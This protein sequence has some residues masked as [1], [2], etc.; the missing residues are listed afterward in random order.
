MFSASALPVMSSD[1][2]PLTQS[3]ECCG[4]LDHMLAECTVFREMPVADRRSLVQRVRA[5]YSCLRSRSMHKDLKYCYRKCLTDGCHSEHHALL[6]TMREGNE[7][8]PEGQCNVNMVC[9]NESFLPTALVPVVYGSAR[10]TA[11]I[12]FD[13]FSQLTFVTK[14]V[15]QQL[16]LPMTKPERITIKG[17]GA[18]TTERIYCKTELSLVPKNE[19]PPVK[20]EA[21]VCEGQICETLAAV[22]IDVSQYTHLMHVPLADSFPR[23]PVELDVLV[24]SALFWR[25][26]EGPVSQPVEAMV[27]FA[28]KTVFG[29][30]LWGSYP[31]KRVT[32][33]RGVMI[34]TLAS[35]KEQSDSHASA[36]TTMHNVLADE[37]DGLA[38]PKWEMGRV[39][40]RITSRDGL[41]R[42][43]RL[44][45]KTG[46]VLR[47]IQKLH[48][49][50]PMELEE[51]SNVDPE[52]DEKD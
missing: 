44:K 38:R 25:F 45:T 12:G 27:P 7:P 47:P 20:I 42:T 15:V 11:R 23:G 50:E 51:G 6:C 29:N 32:S 39:V 28:V 41:V 31:V 5:C 34:T 1:K 21:L 52:S 43:L 9:E 22:P 19:S 37:E 3:C 4:S 8:V 17:F 10:M 2:N 36:A 30:L 40:E 13:S 46:E 35:K 18:K 48:L 49:L 24:G 26:I 16:G 14:K 33:P